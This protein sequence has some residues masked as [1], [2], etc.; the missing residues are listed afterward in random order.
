MI[1]LKFIPL[2][3]LALAASLAAPASAATLLGSYT[4]K[5]GSASGGRS[6]CET[7]VACRRA[8]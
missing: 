2:A 4:H 3:A 1:S 8:R 5:Y 6:R 7:P